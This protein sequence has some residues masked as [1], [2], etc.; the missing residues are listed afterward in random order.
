MKD[1]G[2]T[3]RILGMKIKR[4][5]NNCAFY[6]NQ[7]FYLNKVLSKFAMI[8]YKYDTLPISNILNVKV[9][10]LLKLI[11]VWEDK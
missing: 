2:Q 7:S 8:D 9:N 4:N 3:K 11:K 1:F 6:V 10:N 5:R